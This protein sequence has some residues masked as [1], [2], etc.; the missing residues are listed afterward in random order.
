MSFFIQNTDYERNIS[1]SFE[2]AIKTGLFKFDFDYKV[3]LSVNLLQDLNK[4]PGLG[5][6]TEKNKFLKIRSLFS[7]IVKNCL[8]MPLTCNRLFEI[9]L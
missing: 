3:P 2:A 6:S 5:V 9:L 8:H 4:I 1:Y 7:P